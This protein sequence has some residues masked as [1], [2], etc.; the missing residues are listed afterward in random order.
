MF[1]MQE[2]QFLHYSLFKKSVHN[3]VRC[4]S[5]LGTEVMLA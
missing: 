3:A 5:C 4:F 1:H 2:R